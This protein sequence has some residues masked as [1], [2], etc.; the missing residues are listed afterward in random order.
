MLQ[1]LP[2]RAATTSQPV[3]RKLWPFRGHLCQTERQNK[4]KKIL[5]CLCSLL[6]SRE[7]LRWRW[8][9]IPHFSHLHLPLCQEVTGLILRGYSA[10]PPR[11]QVNSG[12]WAGRGSRCRR[13]QDIHQQHPPEAEPTGASGAL[14][15]G[16]VDPTAQRRQTQGKWK[17][18]LL[19]SMWDNTAE[20]KPRQRTALLCSHP[21]M[22]P[23]TGVGNASRNSCKKTTK[24]LDWAPPRKMPRWHHHVLIHR[25][26]G[27]HT[28]PKP[29]AF[30]QLSSKE[31]L[32]RGSC[33][34][35]PTH[36]ARRYTEQVVP[37]EGSSRL[38]PSHS[39][40]RL[41]QSAERQPPGSPRLQR[42]SWV[43]STWNQHPQRP[44]AEPQGEWL[45]A[46]F[47]V[48]HITCGKLIKQCLLAQ[49]PPI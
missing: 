41:R 9:H 8:S 43:G 42:L 48:L 4:K 10:Q 31:G 37:S 27:N 24:I 35:N 19:S 14:Q 23:E 32:L 33:D 1:N 45:S 11:K 40:L 6:P 28:P 47:L 20:A 7:I 38:C 26:V 46:H 12:V 25:P 18:N 29:G 2:Q 21:K 3:C 30:M 44:P 17:G 34:L 16:R 36:Q 5:S 22:A 39:R 13:V 15:D 49:I